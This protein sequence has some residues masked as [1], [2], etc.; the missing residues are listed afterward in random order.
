MRVD[1]FNRLTG[2]LQR[3]VIKKSGVFLSVLKQ[4]EKDFV[5]Y[6]LDN[7]Y[8]EVVFQHD[9]YRQMSFEGFDSSEVL[10]KYLEQIDISEIR[11]CLGNSA[12]E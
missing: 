11:E 8:V 7:F 9:N 2:V 12:L 3:E 10:E 1:T 4:D 6:Q 5:L